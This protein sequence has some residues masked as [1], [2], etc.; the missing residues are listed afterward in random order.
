MDIQGESVLSFINSRLP[1]SRIN[2][3]LGMEASRTITKGQRLRKTGDKVAEKS[4]WLLKEKIEHDEAPGSSLAR[5]LDRLPAEQVRIIADA[6]EKARITLYLRSEMGQ[7]GF[8]LEP[9]L[10]KRLAEFGIPF[11]VDILSFGMVEE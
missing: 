9:D 3:L 10:L 11:E 2:D 1:E 5:L 6:C 4:I 8:G 7:I